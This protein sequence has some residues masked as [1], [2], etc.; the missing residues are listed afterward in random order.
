MPDPERGTATASFTITVT[1]DYCD[2]DDLEGAVLTAVDP[3]AER[4]N[5][6]IE[7]R[8]SATGL[9]RLGIPAVTIDRL[10]TRYQPI[11]GLDDFDA[12]TESAIRSLP[13][14]GWATY[15]KVRLILD[16]HG[17]RPKGA[18]I[19][20]S[21]DLVEHL[22]ISIEA[23]QALKEAGYHGISQITAK[24]FIELYHDI[25]REA[26]D[27]ADAV[28]KAGFSLQPLPGDITVGLLAEMRASP[29]KSIVN[30]G[31]PAATTLRDL[32][33]AVTAAGSQAAYYFNAAL[34][35]LA[36][37]GGVDDEEGE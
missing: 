6:K 22:T 20:A 31:V 2:A 13:G 8:N 29:F 32:E 28:A 18:P 23:Y 5:V 12:L 9:E 25:H 10:V 3:Y 7:R 35:A 36:K 33:A 37:L 15:R 16:K 30:E 19:L 21:D 27:V 26:N 34:D 1:V 4:K 14:F 11:T 17:H 24:T